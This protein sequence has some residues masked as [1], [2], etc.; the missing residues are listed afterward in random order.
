MGTERVQL[1]VLLFEYKVV[2]VKG[3]KCLEVLRIFQPNSP[4]VASVAISVVLDSSNNRP[5]SLNVLATTPLSA[6]LHNRQ[7]SSS[8]ERHLR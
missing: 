7:G 1:L 3:W 4:N 5:F 6:Y 8:V 2:R